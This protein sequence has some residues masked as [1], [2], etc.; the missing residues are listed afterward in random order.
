L[1]PESQL[2]VSHEFPSM[3]EGHGTSSTFPFNLEF[4]SEFPEIPRL[5]AANLSLNA[6]MT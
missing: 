5:I 6:R 1:L 2:D 4:N 3:P